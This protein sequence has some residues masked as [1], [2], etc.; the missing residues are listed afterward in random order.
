MAEGGLRSEFLLVQ[1]YSPPHLARDMVAFLDQYDVD[2]VDWPA[3]SP[4]MNPMEYIWDQMSI[5][6]R[7]M[8]RP[9]SNLAELHQAVCQVQQAVW[10]RKVRTLVE[11]MAPHV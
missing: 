1:D 3:K 4:D 7:D 11:S 10:S 5:C 2:V 8:D 9:P 6:I